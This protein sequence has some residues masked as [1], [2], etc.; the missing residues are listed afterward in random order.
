MLKPDFKWLVTRRVAPDSKLNDNHFAGMAEGTISAGMLSEEKWLDGGHQE[1]PPLPSS[2]LNIVSGPQEITIKSEPKAEPKLENASRSEFA[3]VEFQYGSDHAN[4][5]A[6]RTGGSAS[7]ED[8]ADESDPQ[9]ATSATPT[10]Y[11][12]VSEDNASESVSGTSE[13]EQEEEERKAGVMGSEMESDTEGERT[14]GE[15]SATDDDEKLAL[16]QQRPSLTSRII[17][18][19]PSQIANF[20]H[21]FCQ[22]VIVGGALQSGKILSSTSASVKTTQKE[23]FRASVGIAVKTPFGAGGSANVN[24]EQGSATAQGQSSTN[25]AGSIVFEATGRDTLLASIRRRG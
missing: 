7:S 1:Q 2:C 22:Q 6:E 15:E 13:S 3:P 5:H 8:G 25:L 14:E 9:S 10:E 18:Q 12:T 19:R 21:V 24:H 20:G 16:Q 23:A 4:G 11:E 17:D